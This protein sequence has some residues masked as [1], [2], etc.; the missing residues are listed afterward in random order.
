MKK[1]FLD[2][3]YRIKKNNFKTWDPY[4]GLNFLPNKIILLIGKWGRIIIIHFFKNIPINLRPF[5]GNKVNNNKLDGI[6]LLI[7]EKAQKL[8]SFKNDKLNF[9]NDSTVILKRILKNSHW[10]KNMCGWG[11]SFPWQNRVFY[12]PPYNPTVVCTY[13]VLLGLEERYLRTNEK[14]ILKYFEGIN[15]YLKK[16]PFR[17]KSKETGVFSYS[18]IDNS[19]CYN[20]SL[21]CAESIS[22][23]ANYIKIEKDLLTKSRMALNYVVN[24][25]NS[26]GSLYYGEDKSQRWVDNFHTIYVLNSVEYLSNYF[27]VNVEDFIRKASVFYKYNL[28]NTDGSLPYY[29]GKNNND[30][31]HVYG[32]FFSSCNKNYFKS[33]FEN[34][35]EKVW[36]YFSQNMILRNKFRYKKYKYFKNNIVYD[37]WSTSWILLGII[38]LIKKNKIK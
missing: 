9:K 7:L 30:D 29:L 4:D 27:Q 38:E 3:Y 10:N 11:Y 19:I 17:K 24:S 36:N 26:D 14:E 18:L 2:N 21:L 23:L 13:F 15:N 35:Y 31:S 34:E 28:I 37:R 22:R 25:I 16:I 1:L 32:T 12:Q 33:C 5:F 6:L 8:D 20:A